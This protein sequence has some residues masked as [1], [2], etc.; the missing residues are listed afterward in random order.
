VYLLDTNI[1]SELTKKRPNPGFVRILRRKSPED[2]FTAPICVTELRFGC[3]LRDDFQ[4]FWSRIEQEILSR[5]TV[6]PF[7]EREALFAGD[8]LATLKREGRI[9]GL[10]DILIAATA[11]ANRLIVVTADTRHFMRIQGLITENWLTP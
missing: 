8:I 4:S 5:V 3:A 6:L 10:E 1:L 2:L 9:I 7:G 11:L